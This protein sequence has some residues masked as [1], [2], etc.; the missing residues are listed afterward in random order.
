MI[1]QLVLFFYRLLTAAKNNNIQ[2]MLLFLLLGEDPNEDLN[3]LFLIK[4]K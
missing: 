1:Y 4:I 3:N 2:G